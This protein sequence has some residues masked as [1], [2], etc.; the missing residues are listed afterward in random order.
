VLDYFT[1]DFSLAL[2]YLIPV[3]L[4]SWFIGRAAGLAIS[5]LCGV[6]LFMTDVVLAP[7]G[8]RL[9][10]IRSWNSPIVQRIVQH[11]GGKIWAEGAPGQG[12]AFYFTL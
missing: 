3:F 6:V 7:A 11:H 8:M 5:L 9:L 1:G 2:F 10:S 12:A 4:A